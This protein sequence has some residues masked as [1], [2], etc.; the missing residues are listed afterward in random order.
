MTDSKSRPTPRPA[1]WQMRLLG[2][3]LGVASAAALP[4]AAHAQAGPT[5]DLVAEV[6]PA[7]APQV[8]GA[9]GLLE[10]ASDALAEADLPQMLGLHDPAA[11]M[12]VRRIT[13]AHRAAPG[14]ANIQVWIE[15]IPASEPVVDTLNA[16][17]GLVAADGGWQH[18]RGARIQVDGDALT[19]WIGGDA[20]EVPSV[21]CPTCLFTVVATPPALPEGPIAL[22]GVASIELRLDAGGPDAA[23]ALTI[24]LTRAPGSADADTDVRAL[25]RA[26]EAV[27]EMPEVDALGF[28]DAL[29]SARVDG[30]A[31]RVQVTIPASGAAWVALM[32][33][34]N[35]LVEA[36][37]Q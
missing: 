17:E 10:Q 33:T 7:V 20:R 18:E 37:R 34:L 31:S 5:W 29:R 25:E 26:L 28:G 9:N 32:Q 35:E 15:G 27:L 21:R 16:A 2:V 22:E 19:A 6:H 14:G 23:A 12:A 11:V 24:A 4:A 13:L 3:L 8:E 1:R 30:S 36:Q